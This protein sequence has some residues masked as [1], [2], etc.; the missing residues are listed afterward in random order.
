MKRLP[1]KQALGLI[2]VVAVLVTV[3]LAGLG[4][5]S[6][7]R[8]DRDS[9]SPLPAE[10]RPSSPVTPAAAGRVLYVDRGR[11]SERGTGSVQDPFDS[12]AQAIEVVRPGDRVEIAS[13]VYR[14]ELAV[15]RSGTPEQPIILAA[16]PGADVRVEGEVLTVDA[17]YISLEG[18]TVEG[19]KDNERG[20]I[21]IVGGT[22]IT[23]RHITAR[24]NEGAGVRV[25]PI[26]R[27]VTGLRI[28]GGMFSRNDGA[29]IAA[30]GE[31]E[32]RDLVIDSVVAHDNDGDGIQ[33]ERAT[34][35]RILH[36]TTT[37]NGEGD[38]RNGVFLKEVV[39][40]LV[41]GLHTQDNG[42]NGL[43]LRSVSGV[44]VARSISVK[45]D[46]HGFDSI[47]R[48]RSVS[49]INNVAYA[50]GNDEEDKGLY[51][52]ATDGIRIVNNIF[53]LNAGDQLAFSD[54]G[55]PVTGIFSDHN[56]FWRA[57]GERL[58]RWFDAYFDDLA[59]YQAASGLD[60]SS[61]QAEPGFVNASD[62]DFR[63]SATSPAL[64]AG[65]PVGEVIGRYCGQAPDIGAVEQACG[66]AE[67][68]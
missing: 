61:L 11:G 32:L 8:L 21:F 3:S 35:V 59:S 34:G 15:E 53:A 28:I 68:R 38:E 23:L 12:I 16:A 41:Y 24:G 13:G 7:L 54:E 56:L 4:F 47:E 5:S 6:W 48:S 39:D 52:T 63:L 2:A 31:L 10:D 66:A 65:A 25:K 22:G 51:V 17:D 37:K 26:E 29:G 67:V 55:G 46:H 1:G 20:G 50:N 57:D 62:R 18:I 42:H 19:A 33:V 60:R 40:A 36:A 58:V 14:E 43:A 44:T 49:Y 30:T 64:D 9:G 45:N 27:P